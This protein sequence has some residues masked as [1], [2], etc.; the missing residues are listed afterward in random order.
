MKKILLCISTALLCATTSNAQQRLSLY[1][2][3]TGENCG[4]CATYNPAF[5]TLLHTG[6]NPT[7]I[8]LIR[9]QSPIPSNGPIYDLYPDVT[10]ARQSYYGVTSAP[11]GRINGNGAVSGSGGAVGHINHLFQTDID[12][13]YTAGSPFNM[14]ATHA[15]SITGD[16]LTATIN[17]SAV[18]AYAPTGANL[19]LRIALIESLEYCAPPGMNGEKAFHYVVREMY[20]NADGTPIPNNWSI[21]QT[22]AY[23]VKGRAPHWVDKSN[24]DA[25][26]IA[27]IQND[28]NKAIPQAAKST[29]ITLGKDAAL[30]GCVPSRMSCATGATAAVTVPVTLK[31]TGTATLTAATIYYKANTGTYTPYNWTGSLATGATATV[32]IP[33]INLP[34]GKFIF[35]DSIVTSNGTAEIN[36]GNNV[37]STPV[38]VINATPNNLPVTTDFENGGQLPPKWTLVDDNRNGDSFMVYSAYNHP[39][40]G[41]NNSKYMLLYNSLIF[42]LNDVNYAILPAANLPAG[43]KTLEFWIAHRQNTQYFS[44]TLD[45]VYSSDCGNTW[46]SVW[47]QTAQAL[48]TVPGYFSSAAYFYPEQGHWQKRIAD[49]S[50][51]PAGSLIAFR[52]VAAYDNNLF[53]DDVNLKAGPTGVGQLIEEQSVKVFPNPAADMT[54]LSFTLGDNTRM[55]IQVCD[56]AGRVIQKVEDQLLHKGKHTYTIPTLSL[57]SGFYL[58]QLITDEGTRSERLSVVK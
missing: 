56:M 40:V 29:R 34:V 58:L 26:I 37:M 32:N 49:L 4:P 45:V 25:V 2:E 55:K 33:A 19:K 41:H 18:A 17:I 42:A 44:D 12:A 1:E 8:L 48:A 51:A 39:N 15:W 10:D 46:T 57:A 3:F 16:T 28:A 7:K 52:A 38:T 14:T 6:A 43:N 22:G 53:I 31:N 5:E 36:R 9:Y 35:T 47:S 50:A 54:Q 23:T 13:A 24:K 30:T 27:W 11:T 20:P 21:G